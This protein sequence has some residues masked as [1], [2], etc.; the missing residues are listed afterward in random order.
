MC[1]LLPHARVALV[2]FANELDRES[3]AA[4]GRMTQAILARLDP[5]S[6]DLF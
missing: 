1:A 5:G 6:A 4:F 3:A 2:A